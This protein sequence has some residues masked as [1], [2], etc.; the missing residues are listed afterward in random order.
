MVGKVLF[1]E[2]QFVGVSSITGCTFSY[3]N[4]SAEEI[5]LENVY[6]PKS[7][8]LISGITLSQLSTI[9][10]DSDLINRILAGIPRDVSELMHHVRMNLN[11]YPPMEL[12]RAVA[13]V[14][15]QT[16]GEISAIKLAV[17]RGHNIDVRMWRCA[18][19]DFAWSVYCGINMH[20]ERLKYLYRLLVDYLEFIN[21]LQFYDVGVYL[22]ATGSRIIDVDIS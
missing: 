15:N 20:D 8:L 11:N 5:K 19:N 16:H 2:C 7:D 13:K 18:Y 4:K 14:S 1:Q 6:V 22:D 9:M 3:G 12:L 10:S 21:K 17:K